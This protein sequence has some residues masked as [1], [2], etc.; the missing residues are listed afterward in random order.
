LPTL[1]INFF[2]V[3]GKISSY[4]FPPLF[5]LTWNSSSAQTVPLGLHLRWSVSWF[6]YQGCWIM[7]TT[8]EG[9][10]KFGYRSERKVGKFKNPTIFWQL[11][12]TYLYKY[13]YF[14]KK[15]PQVTLAH[16]FCTK[17]LSMS[18]TELFNWLI[19]I[20]IIFPK[21]CQREMLV[22]DDDQTFYYWVFFQKIKLAGFL[23]LPKLKLKLKGVIARKCYGQMG[24]RIV[25][26]I[27]LSL[28]WFST[29]HNKIPLKTKEL[30]FLS[31]L[32]TKL[33]MLVKLGLERERERGRERE[34]L[35]FGN[36]Y[37]HIDD[38]HMQQNSLTNFQFWCSFSSCARL[39]LSFLFYYYFILFYK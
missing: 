39:L 27:T 8:Q 20:I 34:P 31:E 37:W 11:A 1:A 6:S 30:F 22:W 5:F 33:W 24:V 2:S 29:H 28:G 13:G 26:S 7:V 23:T 38:K 15:N 9:L 25:E 4:H 12:Q 18:C 16:F 10:A 21:I 35:F 32:Q 36:T 17:I 14:R 3:L 19:I